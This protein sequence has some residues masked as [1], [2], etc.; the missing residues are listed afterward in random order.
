M[1]AGCAV[2]RFDCGV[3]ANDTPKKR[4]FSYGWFGDPT[5]FFKASRDEEALA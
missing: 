2:C 4:G 5:D 3:K 1:S